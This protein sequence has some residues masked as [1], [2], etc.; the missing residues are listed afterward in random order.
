LTYRLRLYQHPGCVNCLLSFDVW[1]GRK[2]RNARKLAGSG[3]AI[4]SQ[5]IA[6]AQLPFDN[7]ESE[8]L[9]LYAS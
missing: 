9:Y 2:V 4:V 5:S 8:R 6:L 3:A 7:W 1:V